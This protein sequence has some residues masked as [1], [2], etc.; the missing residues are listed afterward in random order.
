MPAEPCPEALAGHPRSRGARPSA[1][2]RRNRVS[3][4]SYSLCAGARPVRGSAARRASRGSGPRGRGAPAARSMPRG[5]ARSRGP[6]RPVPARSAQVGGRAPRRQPVRSNRPSVPPSSRIACTTAARSCA[7]WA[8]S[9]RCPAWSEASCRLSVKLRILASAAGRPCSAI[10]ATAVLVRIVVAVGPARLAQG[11]EFAEVARAPVPD[12][13][14]VQADHQAAGLE[15]ADRAPR[16]R[17][18]LHRAV[19]SHS[20]RG[21]PVLGIVLLDP[22]SGL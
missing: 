4:P 15:P 22:R 5:P 14:A 9:L 21:R 8:K 10:R 1:T 2:R 12:A 20:Q 18:G 6:N 19:R 7:T 11:C 16:P 13:A 3:R 17:G